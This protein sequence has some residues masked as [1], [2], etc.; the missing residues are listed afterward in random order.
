[1]R[2]L[3]RRVALITV[4]FYASKEFRCGFRASVIVGIL[5][6]DAQELFIARP[7]CTRY[8][9]V[10]ICNLVY[11]RNSRERE[12]ELAAIVNVNRCELES[13]DALPRQPRICRGRMQNLP[14]LYD[15]RRPRD[16][17]RG[18]SG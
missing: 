6:S 1:M 5:V 14:A 7:T 3:Y 15:A 13:H 8:C 10:G 4:A 11:S 16:K 12:S 17:Q 18:D 9:S 2:L